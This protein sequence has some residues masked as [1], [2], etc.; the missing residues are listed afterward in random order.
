MRVTH[1]PTINMI[2]LEL[3]RGFSDQIKWENNLKKAVVE[4]MVNDKDWPGLQITF[5]NSWR[6]FLVT[7]ER[8]W[9]M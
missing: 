2:N 4:P 7:Q 6:P 9:I 5:V 3:V 1:S 8:L